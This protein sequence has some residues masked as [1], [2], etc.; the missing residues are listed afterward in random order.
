[1]SPQCNALGYPVNSH[2]FPTCGLIV[3]TGHTVFTLSLSLLF[4]R[5]LNTPSQSLPKSLQVAIKCMKQTFATWTECMQLR[6]FRSL[7]AVGHEH[8]NIVQLYE[9]AREANS[10]LYF[11][12][13]YMPDGNLFEFIKRYTPNPTLLAA[14]ITPPTLPEEKIQSILRQSLQALSFLHHKGYVH[15]DMKPENILLKGDTVKLADFGLARETCCQTPLTEY[16]STRWYR[17]PEVLLR[18]KKY[19]KPIDLFGLG[20]IMAELY[21]KVPLFPGRTELDQL[22]KLVEVLGSPN[23]TSWAEFA[24][25]AK[26]IGLVVHGEEQGSGDTDNRAKLD[27][28][29][30]GN[31]TSKAVAD[32]NTSKDPPG[33]TSNTNKPDPTAVGPDDTVIASLEERVPTAPKAAIFFLESLLRWDPN[34]RPTAHEAL[35]DDYFSET[36]CIRP[37]V[38]LEETET[39][40]VNKTIDSICNNTTDKIVAGSGSKRPIDLSQQAIAPQH[41]FYDSPFHAAKRQRR[42]DDYVSPRSINDVFESVPP[43]LQAQTLYQHGLMFPSPLVINFPFY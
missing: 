21:S 14:G 5:I 22:S 29:N 20:C 18:S 24:V 38:S 12:F 7:H 34:K 2:W 11:V 13:E 28:R 30:D 15:R 36:V 35:H 9:V 31:T 17:A 40:A 8:P 19:G 23:K 33:D 4:Y 41:E 26:A 39:V 27:D 42:P 37:I 16:V 3:V 43:A 25:L 32:T 1:M 6:E 10:Q